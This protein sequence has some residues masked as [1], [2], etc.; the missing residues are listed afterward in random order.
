MAHPSKV[1]IL[2]RVYV[3]STNSPNL[4]RAS[5]TPI[6]CCMALPLQRAN[7]MYTLYNL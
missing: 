5:V 7:R 6:V 4:L 1:D 2:I 3:I